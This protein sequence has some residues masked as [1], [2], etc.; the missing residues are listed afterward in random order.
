MQTNKHAYKHTYIQVCMVSVGG[1]ADLQI[2]T[3]A[4]YIKE[5]EK[6]VVATV[7]NLALCDSVLAVASRVMHLDAD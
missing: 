7:R 2:V 5:G 1:S 4:K 6:V 3:N